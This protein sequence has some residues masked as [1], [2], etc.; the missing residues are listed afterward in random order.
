MKTCPNC[1]E[2]LGTHADNCFSCRYDFKLGRVLS[3]AEKQEVNKR[4]EAIAEMKAE[5]ERKRIEYEKNKRERE[6]Q[7]RKDKLEFLQK[8][9]LYEYDTVV[10]YD[11]RSGGADIEAINRTLMAYAKDG[12]KLHTAFTNEVGKNSSSVG[13]GGVSI[14]TN[15]TMDQT[16]LIFERMIAKG[17][18]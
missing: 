15:S 16:V 17:S 14:G 10:V 12:W 2:I 8:L 11:K 4:N 18:L 9:P 1:G 13:Y 7:A 3:D 6:E 5:E